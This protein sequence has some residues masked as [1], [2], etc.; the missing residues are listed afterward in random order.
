[1]ALVSEQLCTCSSFPAISVSA[2]AIVSRL[3]DLMEAGWSSQTLAKSLTQQFQPSPLVRVI[4]S[5]LEHYVGD[6][7]GRKQELFGRVMQLTRE[8]FALFDDSHPVISQQL[9]FVRRLSLFDAQS[10]ATTNNRQVA[11]LKCDS[12]GGRV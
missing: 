3:A 4:L 8:T 9:A 12:V 10:W 5:G 11:F 6:E 2:G 7:A 1:M